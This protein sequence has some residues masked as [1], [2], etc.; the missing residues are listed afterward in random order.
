MKR[1]TMILL[2]LLLAVATAQA[3]IQIDKRRPAP[4]KGEVYIENSF[5]SLK[6]IGWDKD[7]IS[8]TGN[9][10]SGAEG[11]ELDGDSEGVYVDVDVPES[12]FYESDDDSDYQSHLV[13]HVPFGSSLGIET[14][15]ASIEIGDVRGALSVETINGDVRI[16]GNPREVE[17]ETMTGPVNVRAVSAPME[18]ESVSG[19]VTLSGVSRELYVVTVSGAVQVG[20]TSLQEVDIQTTSGDVRFDGGFTE[21]G[22]L[23]IETH[24]GHVELI[25]TPGVKARFE[26]RTF[27]GQ[28][29]NEMGSKPRRDGRFNPFTELRFS[30]GLNEF[31]VG[32]ETFSGD[33]TLRLKS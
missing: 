3:Q 21:E 11:L 18:I 22:D 15:N 19:P 16:D 6:V 28:I 8:V 14:V 33:I 9:L 30:T 13:V 27:E 25:L 32:V 20:G 31:E 23:E 26:C 12:W 24:S 29:Q 2:G 4:S 5:G 7:E 17:V 10:A 1:L